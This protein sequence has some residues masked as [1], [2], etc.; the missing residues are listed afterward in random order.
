MP[1]Q[2]DR[3]YVL[4]RSQPDGTSTLLVCGA[5][6]GGEPADVF[7]RYAGLSKVR[8]DPS[9]RLAGTGATRYTM[10]MVNVAAVGS[11]V[12]V[13]ALPRLTAALD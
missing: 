8:I 9:V 12:E 6:Q 7:A 10:H 3:G 5:V 4:L 13:S 1:N 11:T 2:N